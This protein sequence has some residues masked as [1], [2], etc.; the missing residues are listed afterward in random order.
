M[1]QM[2]YTYAVLIQGGMADMRISFA[3]RNKINIFVNLMGS[4]N[5]EDN[6]GIALQ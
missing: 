4:Q 1:N 6:N 5:W 2:V 3:P